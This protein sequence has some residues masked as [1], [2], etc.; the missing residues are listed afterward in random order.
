MPELINALWKGRLCFV[1][2]R[3]YVGLDFDDMISP[4]KAEVQGQRFTKNHTRARL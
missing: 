2:V 3:L 4:A 1:R